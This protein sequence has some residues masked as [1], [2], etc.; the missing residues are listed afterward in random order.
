M[1]E[2]FREFEYRVVAPR[3]GIISSDE[4]IHPPAQRTVT[5][6]R[7]MVSVSST[8]RAATQ[9]HWV[10][11]SQGAG[12]CLELSLGGVRV[13]R[14]VIMDLTPFSAHNVRKLTRLRTTRLAQL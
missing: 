11:A 4:G 10:L 12:E 3:A 7:V 1:S 14:G 6:G 8:P 5:P 9:P 2:A 13:K